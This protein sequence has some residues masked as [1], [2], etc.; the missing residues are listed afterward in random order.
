M[1][2]RRLVGRLLA[3]GLIAASPPAAGQ[4]AAPTSAGPAER[5]AGA[6]AVGQPAAPEAVRAVAGAAERAAGAGAA[7]QPAA[8][9]TVREPESGT[10]FPVA[11]TPPGGTTPH[12][13]IGTGIRQRTIFR[14]NVYAFGLYVDADGARAALA[15]FAGAAAEALGRDERFTRRLLDLDFGMALRLVM[16]RT[17]SG[18]DV[19]GAFDDALR[20]RMPRTGR[21]ADGDAAAALATL[22]GYLDVDE[23]RRGVEI[24]FSCGPAGRLAMTVDGAERVP[25][26]SPS[27][28]RALFD[29][30]LGER[31][32]EREGR[33]N[34]I[35]GF[36]GLLQPLDRR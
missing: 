26:E 18:G 29:I 24:V 7:G 20:P 19:A 36:A 35:A 8:P 22:R 15:D 9:D 16:T 4:S 23:V 1:T 11:L 33:R 32:I 17:V 31:P 13:L 6:G 34:L 3:L 5:A 30:Y 25:I 28:C 14:V 2:A 27:L 12:R 10:L 21:G